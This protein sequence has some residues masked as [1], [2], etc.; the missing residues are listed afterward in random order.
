M[1][2]LPI[3][4]SRVLVS[5]TANEL[6]RY[7]ITFDTMSVNDSATRI[8]LGDLFS[9]LSH[10][11]LRHFGDRAVI[12]CMTRSNG[13][14]D[15]LFTLTPPV[16]WL[17]ENLDDLLFS[18]TAGVLPKQTYTIKQYGAHWLVTPQKPL[19]DAESLLLSEFGTPI[20]ESF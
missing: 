8:L 11:K 13:S 1:T 6:N 16:R 12:D 2:I 4:D 17:F 9:V 20:S 15:M 18:A 14:C 7:S 5:I 3:S 10:M 19:S